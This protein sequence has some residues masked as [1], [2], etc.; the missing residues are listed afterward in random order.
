MDSLDPSRSG[1][2]YLYFQKLAP[3][4]MHTICKPQQPIQR[5]SHAQIKVER[6]LFSLLSFTRTTSL[7][8][9]M[10]RPYYSPEGHRYNSHTHSSI[11]LKPMLQNPAPLPCSGSSFT[12]GPYNPIASYPVHDQEIDVLA[13]D[14]QRLKKRIRILKLVSRII[15]LVLSVATL[16]PLTTTLAKFL[17]TKDDFFVVNG[18]ERTAWAKDSVT[19]YTYMYF[20]VAFVSFVFDLAVVV[21]YCRGVKKANKIAAVATWWSTTVQVGHVLVWIVGAAIY[22]Y[23]KE[24][25]DGKFEDLWGW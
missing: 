8:T 13:A 3:M 1:N 15:A 5:S 2:R 10:S 21:A 11:S 18:Q 14:D 4:S 17:T 19:W 23:G 12:N 22:R 25:V 7:C 6:S 24:P 9:T 16:V 20:G